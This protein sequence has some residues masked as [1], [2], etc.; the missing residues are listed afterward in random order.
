MFMSKLAW[1]MSSAFLVA[2][3]MV[4]LPWRRFLF[5]MVAVAASQYLVLLTIAT[6]MGAV[7]GPADDIFGWFKIIVA[8]VLAIVILYLLVARRLRRTL[9]GAT[10]EADSPAAE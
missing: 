4:R 10:K 9:L 3:G 8:A 5:L 7:I 1:G 6:A 2:A